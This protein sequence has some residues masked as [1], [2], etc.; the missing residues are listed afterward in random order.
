MKKVEEDEEVRLTTFFDLTT[1]GLTPP[2][3]LPQFT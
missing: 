3:T 2:R 1:S